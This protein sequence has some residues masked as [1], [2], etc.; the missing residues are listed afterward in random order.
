VAAKRRPTDEDS[1]EAVRLLTEA[2]ESSGDI[3]DALDEIRPLHPNNNTFP[4]EVFMRVAADAL[5]LGGVGID[6]SMPSEGLV[7]RYLPECRFRGRENR[8]IRYALLAVAATNGGVEV[9][10]LDEVAYGGP[11]TSGATRALPRSLGSGPFRIRGV[12]PLATCAAS[13]AT[14][15]PTGWAASQPCW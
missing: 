2:V 9:D 8:K 10:L 5:R 13:Y 6:R 7:D 12:C 11:T 1:R 4:G 14:V 3:F 15:T